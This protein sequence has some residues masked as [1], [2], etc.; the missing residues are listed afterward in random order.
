M[1]KQLVLLG[2]LFAA[3][4]TL[5]SA[6]IIPITKNVAGEVA[7]RQA[8][9]QPDRLRLAGWLGLRIDA[10][11]SNRLVKLD[12]NRLLEGYRKR[13][14]RQTWDGEH[15]GKWLHAATLPPCNHVALRVYQSGITPPKGDT[16]VEVVLGRQSR[17]WAKTVRPSFIWW[18][19]AG[20]RE[21]TLKETSRN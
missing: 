17:S 6:T 12:V 4:S 18:K 9:N 13:P 10:S 7:D 3:N 8:F 20:M 11:E 5:V 14:G 15:V 16:L 2:L 1:R 21:A 19:T